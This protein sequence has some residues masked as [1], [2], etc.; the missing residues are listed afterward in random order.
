M[1]LRGDIERMHKP[2]LPRSQVQMQRTRNDLWLTARRAHK[3]RHISYQ[4]I[5][6]PATSGTSRELNTAPKFSNP[7]KAST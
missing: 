3:A 1:K 2:M 6:G 5:S 4:G 7:S